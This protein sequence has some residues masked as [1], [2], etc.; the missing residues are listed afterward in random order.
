[1]MSKESFLIQGC[2]VLHLLY[3]NSMELCI[4]FYREFSRDEKVDVWETHDNY[5]W[6]LLMLSM[7][8][9]GAFSNSQ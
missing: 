2:R 1:M 9:C 5:F 6:E 3:A 7:A 4:R 8:F